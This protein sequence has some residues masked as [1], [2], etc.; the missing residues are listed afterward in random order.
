[1]DIKLVYKSFIETSISLIQKNKKNIP[2]A[3]LLIWY[4]KIP[5]LLKLFI[6]AF[7][8][9][10]VD[11]VTYTVGF[12][13]LQSKA[14]N[15]AL[16]F[17]SAFQNPIDFPNNLVYKYSLMFFSSFVTLLLP[18]LVVFVLHFLLT[19]KINEVETNIQR[20]K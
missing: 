7:A 18:F 15:E 10:I 2:F 12:I 11:R 5:F 17:I 9:Y 6:A 13:I 19:N 1:M 8:G 20:K 4:L 16:S 3:S 14:K